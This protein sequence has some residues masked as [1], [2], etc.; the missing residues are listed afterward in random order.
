MLQGRIRN[1]YT[2]LAELRKVNETKDK[3]PFKDKKMGEDIR[4]HRRDH[5]TMDK[6]GNR[7]NNEIEESI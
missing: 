3:P 1:S 4:N 5:R 7:P 2:V 6:L